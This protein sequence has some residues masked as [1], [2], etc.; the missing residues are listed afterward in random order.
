MT[1]RDDPPAPA[2]LDV[3]AHRGFAGENPENTV[4]AAVAAADRGA[5][6]V[7]V[8][9]VPTASGDV[10]VFHDDR[11]A[12]R[13]GAKG[14]TDAEGVVWETDTDTVTGAEVLDSGETVPRLSEV[15]AAVPAGVGVNVEL[16]NPGRADLRVG[17]YLS[18][19]ALSE[20]TAVWRPFVERVLSVVEDHDNHVLFSSFCEAPLAVVREASSHPIAPIAYESVADGTA[21][22]RRHDAE[23]IHPSLGAVL[24]TAGRSGSPDAGLVA[25][26]H[27]EGRRVNA[28]TVATWRH[29]QR[30]ADAGVDGI[31]ADYSGLLDRWTGRSRT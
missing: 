31:I 27:A 23:A 5:D 28:W 3:I 4:A 22:A 1:A 18:E 15:L 7:E 20:R 2:D 21:V 8:D 25:T 19:S 17:E 9:A 26:A 14:L 13:E 6:L 16:K 24:G 10:V 11:L 12:G 29:A 30:L